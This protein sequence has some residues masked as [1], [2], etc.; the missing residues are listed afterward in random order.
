MPDKNKQNKEHS[1]IS[2]RIGEVQVEFE[3]T[4]ENIKKL[5]NKE[6]LDFAKQLEDAAKQLPAST[7]VAPEAGPKTPKVVLKP[8][9]ASP[10][11]M[12]SSVSEVPTKKGQYAIGKK[13]EKLG[14]KGTNWQNLAIAMIM[15]CI[16]LLASV[17]GVT[18]FHFSTVNDLESLIA[19]KDISVAAL[20]A[21]VTSLNA[22][23]SSLDA[24]VN[25]YNSTIGDLREAVDILNAINQQYLSLLFLN[26]SSY[27]VAPTNIIQNA[28]ESTLIYTFSLDYAGYVSVDVESTS[29]TTYVQLLYSYK[30]VYYNHNVTVAED[31]TAYFPVLPAVIEIWIGNTEMFPGDL[32]NATVSA[33]YYY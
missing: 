27:L 33:F 16:V 5:M 13:T 25:Q 28:S 29:N 15:V 7:E 20:S 9:A 19:E 22:Q 11:S 4:S 8:N 24:T 6:M 31:G 21:N 12:P 17:I 10:T 32:V 1:K 14:K 30:E 3:G 18:A 23:V 26:E 2:M